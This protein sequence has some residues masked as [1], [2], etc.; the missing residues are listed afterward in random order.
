MFFSHYAILPNVETARS[1]RKDD[2]R[3]MT[4]GIE[5]LRE[6]VIGA[7]FGSENRSIIRFSMIRDSC[8]RFVLGNVSARTAAFPTYKLMVY[9]S[10]G[11]VKLYFK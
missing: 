3:R 7:C 1:V 6:R 10:L 4:T 5:D 9:L 11:F 2:S 8:S